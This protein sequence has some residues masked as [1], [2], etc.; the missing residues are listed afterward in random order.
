MYDAAT[1]KYRA[2]KNAEYSIGDYKTELAAY[3]SAK[4][5]DT[6]KMT[7]VQREEYASRIAEWERGLNIKKKFIE[8][9][10]AAE[11]MVQRDASGNY[12][13]EISGHMAEQ[14]VSN[15]NSNLN[16][17][18]EAAIMGVGHTFG[19]IDTS[20]ANYLETFVG[21]NSKKYADRAD[22]VSKSYGG[23]DV[24]R[25]HEREKAAAQA[26]HGK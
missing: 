7:D 19:T 8:G 24:V 15:I 10:A 5:I 14:L 1:G 23:S 6:S 9:Q 11:W 4:E 3:N 13:D 25:R 12:H 21:E 17:Y 2:S 26:K 22:I 20:A 16:V 18:G